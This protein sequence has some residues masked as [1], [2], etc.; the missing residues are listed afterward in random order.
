MLASI[1]LAPA[2]DRILI[3]KID[4]PSRS[5]PFSSIHIFLQVS[6]NLNRVTS[7]SK[8][9]KT[10]FSTIEPIAIVVIVLCSGKQVLCLV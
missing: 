10:F 8:M 2:S 6:A 4:S 9:R 1:D 5:W 3:R 7:T